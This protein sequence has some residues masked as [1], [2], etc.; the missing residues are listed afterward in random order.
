METNVTGEQSELRALA[1]YLQVTSRVP[2][3]DVE[4]L[5]RAADRLDRLTALLGFVEEHGDA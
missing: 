5:R 3:A 2:L 1:D 4:L